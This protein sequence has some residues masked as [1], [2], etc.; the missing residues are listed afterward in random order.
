[1]PAYCIR[2]TENDYGNNYIMHRKNDVNCQSILYCRY[3]S[4]NHNLLSSIIS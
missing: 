3:N 4:S 2:N 1:M